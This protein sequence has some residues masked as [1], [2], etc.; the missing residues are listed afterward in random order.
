MINVNFRFA[1]NM[2]SLL[3]ALVQR[4]PWWRLGYRKFVI[5]QFC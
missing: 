2:I 5:G 4:G 3:W 1:F